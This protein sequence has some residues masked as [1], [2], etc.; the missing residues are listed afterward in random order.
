MLHKKLT[1]PRYRVRVCGK[2]QCPSWPFM[3][4]F[5]VFSKPL[6]IPLRIHHFA[7]LNR[8]FSALG[9]NL[10][11]PPQPLADPS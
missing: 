7:V 11:S 9:G 3:D 2:P 8:Y 5:R 1:G 6:G 10:F 4:P